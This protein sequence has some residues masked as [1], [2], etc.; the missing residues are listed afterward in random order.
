VAAWLLLALAAGT[1]HA[2]AISSSS[3]SAL[4]ADQQAK[5]AGDL[6]STLTLSKLPKQHT[7]AKDGTAPGG[8]KKGG[9][10]VR[11]V[12]ALVFCNCTDPSMTALRQAVVSA[13]GSVYMRYLSVRGLS[14][15][16]PAAGVLK[17]AARPE[18]QSISPNRLTTRSFSVLEQSANISDSTSVRKPG[19]A[20]KG[21]VSTYTGRTGAGVGIA[22][23]DSG[24]MRNHETF[25][26]RVRHAVDFTKTSDASVAGQKDWTAGV[27]VSGDLLNPSSAARQA[28]ETRINNYAGDPEVDEYGHGTHVASVAA[29]R[30]WGL[31]PNS[32]GIAPGALLVDLKVLDA[33]GFGAVSDVLA[34][35]DWVVLRGREHNIRVM[36]LSLAADSTESHLT[37]CA[38]PC[39]AR[40]PRA[41]RWSWRLAISAR[42]AWAGRYT[43]RSVPQGSSPPRSRWVRPRRKRRAT[44][45]S[46]FRS[47]S[48]ARAARPGASTSPPMARAESRTA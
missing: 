21:V 39:A 24:I 18:V 27:D 40:W 3:I 7:W 37:P 43:A 9:E 22:I 13:G 12:K 15:M 2:S 17:I 48:S 38:E 33:N 14:V 45:D 25:G 47:T 19:T 30:A 41:S 23:L 46:R 11:Y 36:N 8:G 32:T 44:T 1:A 5:L 28:Y 29:G 26:T 42:T 20:V 34:A 6:R 35:I 4:P 31:N 16:L 10:T